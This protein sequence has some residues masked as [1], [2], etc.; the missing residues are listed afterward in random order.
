MLFMDKTNKNNPG[1]VNDDLTFFFFIRSFF[2]SLCNPLFGLI[3][4]LF[5]VLSIFF[6]FFFLPRF[7]PLYFLLSCFLLFPSNLE[8]TQKHVRLKQVQ[9]S[10]KSEITNSW[11]I[12]VHCYLYD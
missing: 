5:S 3:L 2:I 4:N 9:D 11:F 12:Y 8:H 1:W 10:L 7:Y 6:L